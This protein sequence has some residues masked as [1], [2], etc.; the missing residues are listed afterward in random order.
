[1]RFISVQITAFVD[2]HQPGFVECS[3]SDAQGQVHTFIEKAPVVSRES[4]W[5]D[6][7]YPRPGFIACELQ[8]EW[9][10]DAER[11]LATVS[12]ELPWG[13][14]STEGLQQFV[15]LRSQLI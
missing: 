13:I 6:S 9:T 11:T 12:T 15:L 10:D 5:S 8:T 4:L 14:E 3:L 1:M 2:D 7:D